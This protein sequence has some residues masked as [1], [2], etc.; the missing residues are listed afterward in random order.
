MASE[1]AERQRPSRWWSW[2]RFDPGVAAAKAAGSAD[3]EHAGDQDRRVGVV[4]WQRACG[5][6]LVGVGAVELAIV[7]CFLVPLR[8]GTVP[9]P[10]SVVLAVVGNVALTRLMWRASLHRAVAG[11]PVVVWLVAVLVLAAK[12]QE[13]DLVVPG[14]GMGL[15]F[16]FLGTIAGAFAVGQVIAPVR[17][18]PGQGMS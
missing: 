5:S 4:G 13:G 7:E 12:R 3:A 17:R 11:V 16:L 18:G 9:L 10:V 8:V 14:T 2:L 1:V 15:A 6:V